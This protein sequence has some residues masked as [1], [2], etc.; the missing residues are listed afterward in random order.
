[1]TKKTLQ[2]YLFIIL[3][4]IYSI[5][6]I[7]SFFF[8]TYFLTSKDITKKDILLHLRYFS[9]DSL[10]GRYPSTSGSI[11][12]QKWIIDF[13]NKWEYIP[14]FDGKYFLEFIFL[15]HYKKIGTNELE[16]LDCKKNCKVPVEPLPFSNSGE[17]VGKVIDGNHC[18]E[19]NKDLSNLLTKINNPNE[20]IVLCKRLAPE[21]NKNKQSVSLEKKYKNINSLNF[22][23]VIFLKDKEP[24]IKI[25]QFPISN[26]GKTIAVFLDNELYTETYKEI[27]KPNQ[28]IKIV[29]NYEQDKLTG[30]TLGFSLKPLKEDQKI[31]YLGAHYDHLGIGIAGFSLGSYGEIYN[32]ADDNASGVVGIM[33]L[34]EFFSKTKIPED[35]NLVFLFFDAEEWG[36][37]GSK[38]FVNSKYFKTNSIAML[39]FDMIGRYSESLQVQGKDTG[40]TIWKEILNQSIQ[41]SQ[42][43]YN[44][45]I[46]LVAGGSGPSDH[47]MFYRKGIP[48]L[49]FFT[50]MHEDYHKPTDDYHKIN[51]DKMVEILEF[52]KETVISILNSKNIPKFV[53]NQEEKKDRSYSVRLGIIPSNYF[54]N[55]GIEIGGF[56]ENAPIS[57]SGI[58]IGDLIVK[59]EDKEIQNIY[60]LMDFLQTAKL[61]KR[62]KIIYKRNNKLYET[63]TELIGK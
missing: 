20:Y 8:P 50:G 47:T 15:G 46:Q 49:F 35:W 45:K 63:Y 52:A 29:I 3:I 6:A 55:N 7:S 18:I 51:Y 34:A 44:L 61:G 23:G 58:Q 53:K 28:E 62:Y 59:I 39:N 5:L 54:S 2:F 32:G 60:N 26:K 19:E 13:F 38:E 14:L 22:K 30:R 48:V 33:E 11:K 21:E 9:D 57:R 31:L 1:M 56:V 41:K 37:L 40:D 25:E 27:V 17:I 16:L 42:S 12:A 36:L 24:H 10:N 4:L 43:K